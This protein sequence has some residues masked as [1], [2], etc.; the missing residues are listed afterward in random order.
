MWMAGGR[1]AKVLTP[2]T[3]EKK[4]LAGH[5]DELRWRYRHCR[6]IHVICDNAR[7]HTARGSRLVREYLKEWGHRVVLHYL[8]GYSPDANPIER[9]W[10]R[11]HEQVTRNHRCRDLDD[12]LDLVFQWLGERKTFSTEGRFYPKANAGEALTAF[13]RSY[14]GIPELVVNTPE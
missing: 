10:W 5:L 8:P 11:M 4:Y 14:L 12:L 7:F 13:G 1:Q 2:G 6:A 3:E 9:V